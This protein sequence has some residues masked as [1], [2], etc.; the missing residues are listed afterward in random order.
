MPDSSD[1]FSIYILSL[2]NDLKYTHQLFCFVFFPRTCLLSVMWRRTG[3]K[4]QQEESGGKARMCSSQ[5]GLL[6]PL[7]WWTILQANR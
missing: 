4:G 5:V 2:L 6:G 7:S 1:P 3:C